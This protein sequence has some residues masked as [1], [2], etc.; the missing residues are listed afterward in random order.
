MFSSVD[1]R[2]ATQPTKNMTATRLPIPSG[3]ITIR[4]RQMRN[5]FQCFAGSIYISGASGDTEEEAAQ[6]LAN[7]YEVRAGT[8][9]KVYG[10]K[11]PTAIEIPAA[12]IY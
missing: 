12:D 5:V 10:Y 9:A 1:R 2:T 4:H 3:K 11:T 6:Q 8:V 7:Q